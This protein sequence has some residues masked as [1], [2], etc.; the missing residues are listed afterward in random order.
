MKKPHEYKY[1]A[2]WEDIEINKKVDNWDWYC[3]KCHERKEKGTVVWGYSDTKAFVNDDIENPLCEV[4]ALCIDC[5]ESCI[6]LD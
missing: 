1:M 5:R 2:S 3:E 6:K 4:T